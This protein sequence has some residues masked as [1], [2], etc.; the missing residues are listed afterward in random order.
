MKKVAAPLLS[1]VALSL[2]VFSLL[3]SVQSLAAQNKS[4]S[5]QAPQKSTAPPS[6]TV[7]PTTGEIPPV[8]RQLLEVTRKW[9]NGDMSTPGVSAEIRE[10]SRANSNGRLEVQYHVFVT[11]APK[12]QNYDMVTWPINAR[13]PSPAIAGLSLLKDGLISCAGRTP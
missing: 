12:D 4:P 11:G 8:A 9:L 10:V 5:A 13:G 6:Q 3:G 7:A 1:L 2:L